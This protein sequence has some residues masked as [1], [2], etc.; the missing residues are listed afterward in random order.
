MC[1]R[2]CRGYDYILDKLTFLVER[3]ADVHTAAGGSTEVRVNGG[4]CV[5]KE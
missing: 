1:I 4:L 5:R 3:G 2:Q